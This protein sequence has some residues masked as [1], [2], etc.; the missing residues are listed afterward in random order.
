[1][2]LILAQLRLSGQKYID[3]YKGDTLIK[4]DRNTYT[5]KYSKLYKR[6]YVYMHVK[7]ANNI[8]REDIHGIMY[9]FYLQDTKTFDEVVKETFTQ[10]EL[11]AMYKEMRVI[12]DSEPLTEWWIAF[13]F[14]VSVNK[15]TEGIETFEVY[16]YD[17]PSRRNISLKKIEQ[18]ENK[19]RE[20]VRFKLFEGRRQFLQDADVFLHDYVKVLFKNVIDDFGSL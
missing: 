10:E 14:G 18:M 4:A 7:N 17:T 3:Y 20:R 5:I 11:K 19:L 12:S 13:E 1:M 9:V 16:F 8:K 2:C 6:P 15:Y